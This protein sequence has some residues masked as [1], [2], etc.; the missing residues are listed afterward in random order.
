MHWGG[1]DGNRNCQ[2]LQQP[3]KQFDQA[4]VKKERT[5]ITT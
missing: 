1:K 4:T 3:C 2:Q 5:K